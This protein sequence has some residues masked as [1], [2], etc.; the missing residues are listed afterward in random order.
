MDHA[1]ILA[2][3]A[4]HFGGD[5][6]QRWAPSGGDAGCACFPADRTGRPVTTLCTYGA[7]LAP[8]PLDDRAVDTDTAR[9]E[10]VAY[11]APTEPVPADLVRWMR[12]AAAFPHLQAP[13]TYVG[14]GHTV[15]LGPLFPESAL[16]TLLFLTPIVR[17]DKGTIFSIGGDPVSFLWL[18]FLTDAEH[19]ACRARGPNHVLDL[20]QQHRHPLVFT[21]S[22][23]SYV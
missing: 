18:T 4:H 1:T 14:W 3:L 22:R 12:Y 10:L 5:A 9:V 7:S 19:A 17:P 11:L 13:P 16:S 6:S 8:M 15:H 23:S 21:P 2:S 20:F